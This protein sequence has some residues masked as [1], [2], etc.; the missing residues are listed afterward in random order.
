MCLTRRCTSG[1]EKFLGD[2]DV[3]ISAAEAA[4][5]PVDAARAVVRRHTLARLLIPFLSTP[6]AHC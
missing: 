6:P 2:A 5:L 3:L 1:Q 4:G